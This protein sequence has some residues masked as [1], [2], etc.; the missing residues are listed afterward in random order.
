MGGKRDRP[1]SRGKCQQVLKRS[2][3]ETVRRAE[4]MVSGADGAIINTSA[5]NL[6]RNQMKE[7]T[8]LN[9]AWDDPAVVTLIWFKEYIG[10]PSP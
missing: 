10:T 5:L 8:R 4:T 3:R 9:S 7:R 6:K 1:G 2:G